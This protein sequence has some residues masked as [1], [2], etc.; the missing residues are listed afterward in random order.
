M[1]RK[2]RGLFIRALHLLS[3]KKLKEKD[4]Q[5]TTYDNLIYELW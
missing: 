5:R 1:T 2:D 3:W 4:N